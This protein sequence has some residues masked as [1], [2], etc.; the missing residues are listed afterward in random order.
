MSSYDLLAVVGGKEKR[1]P[2]SGLTMDL[3]ALRI[4]ASNLSVAETGSKFDFGSVALLSTAVPSANGDLV[5]KL[6]LDNAIAALASGTEW[7]DSILS[8]LADPP[9]SPTTGDRHLVIAT[10]TGAWV[11]E[12]DSIAQYNG[13]TWLFTSPVTGMALLNDAEPTLMYVY[14]S[15]SWGSKSFESTTAS[16]FLDKTGFDIT[17]KNL[18]DGKI[19]LGNGSGVAAAVTMSGDVTM[20]NAGVVTIGAA[21]VTNAMLAGSIAD[22]KLSTIATANKVSGSAVQLAASGGLEDSSGLQI[23]AASVTSAML[24]GSIADSKLSTIT[25]ANKVSGS[26]VQLKSGGG[27]KDDSGLAQQD[28]ISKTND[29]AGAITIRQIV[30]VKADGDVDLAKADVATLDQ[31]ELGIVEVASIA[32]AAAGLIVLK[33]GAIV[34]GFTALT[35]GAPVYVSRATAGAYQQDLSGF[36]AGEFVYMVGRAVSATEVKYAPKFRFE[37]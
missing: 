35:P 7:Q 4:G 14:G 21:K 11:G 26:A 10:A 36:V 24:A 29:N 23:K 27:L 18:V 1:L 28:A 6:A 33:E 20:D 9:G 16:G 19:I 13:A 25:T 31:F 30:Y 22:S 2:S 17:L 34:G 12:E 15:S 5:N 3:T 37:Y 32:A 8:K